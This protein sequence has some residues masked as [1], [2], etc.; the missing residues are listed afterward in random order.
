MIN[1]DLINNYSQFFKNGYIE[2]E[3][4]FGSNWELFWN[5]AAERRFQL[6]FYPF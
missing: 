3:V 5:F 4:L 6:Q 2:N 1:T